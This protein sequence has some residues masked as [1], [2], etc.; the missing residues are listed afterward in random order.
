M[1]NIV[2][3]QK[4]PDFRVIAR[5]Q[6]SRGNLKVKG[7]ASRGEARPKLR[8]DIQLRCVQR[9]KKGFLAV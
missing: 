5:P 2:F 4:R 1:K 7:T 6:R 8:N 3:K 9:V